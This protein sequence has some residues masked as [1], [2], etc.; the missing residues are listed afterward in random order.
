MKKFSLFQFSLIFTFIIGSF[1]LSSSFRV[2]ALS[3]VIDGV[4]TGEAQLSGAS[5]GNRSNFD[6]DL[7]LSTIPANINIDSA[8]LQ[9]STSGLSSTGSV[10]II[11][12]YKPSSSNTIDISSLGTEGLRLSNK[13]LTNITD[14]YANPSHNFGINFT[15]KN[16]SDTD[17]IFFN[18]I[19]LI[20]ITSSK[21]STP[22]VI[23]KKEITNPS[24][25]TYLF[26]INTDESSKLVINIGKSSKYDQVFNDGGIYATTHTIPITGLQS[27]ITY[28][29]QIVATDVNGNE[30]K[31]TDNTFLTGI[32][33][34]SASG[35]FIIDATLFPPNNLS[36]ELAKKSGAYS[37][38]LSWTPSINNPIDGYIVYRKLNELSNY[39]EIGKAN[40]TALGYI[41]ET[42]EAGLKYDYRVHTYYQN[43]ISSN[44]SDLTV[45]IPGDASDNST[46]SPAITNN[47][48]QVLLI[49]F[50][51]AGV[52]YLIIYGAIRFFP[53]VFK[54]KDQKN[55]H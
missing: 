25:A 20:V 21:D 23:S 11:D 8:I 13:I 22:P 50:A 51:V 7:S 31:T 46:L 6:V 37:V 32:T 47:T 38:L 36:N 10:T 42:V 53:N 48:G 19:R 15:G 54:K 49:L 18:S 30:L 44:S 3:Y 39:V 28:H 40:S 29:Y 27:G 45:E 14:W 41:D 5:A 35:E 12:R 9:Y 2:N 55:K 52:L 16:L 17:N 1:L 43:K 34:Q 4:V 26:S 24:I 33:I